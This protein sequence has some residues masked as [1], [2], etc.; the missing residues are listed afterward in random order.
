MLADANAGLTD[1]ATVAALAMPAL[2][3]ANPKALLRE[4]FLAMV[5]S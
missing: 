2:V 4:I 3:A 1:I 5:Q